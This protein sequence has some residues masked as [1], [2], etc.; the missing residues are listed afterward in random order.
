MGQLR[1]EQEEE[2]RPKGSHFRVEDGG[3]HPG[4]SDRKE[5]FWKS[6]DLG[7]KGA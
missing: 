7:E 3:G 1:Q 5:S 6:G 2:R 4:K